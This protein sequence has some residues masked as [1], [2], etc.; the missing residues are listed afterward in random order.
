MNNKLIKCNHTFYIKSCK[1][2]KMKFKQYK[3]FESYSFSEF[4]IKN[5]KEIEKLNSNG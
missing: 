4:Y 3:P 5:Q 1:Y 2:C